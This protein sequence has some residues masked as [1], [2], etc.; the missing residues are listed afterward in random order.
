MDEIKIVQAKEAKNSI[1]KREHYSTLI[2]GL[3]IN[4]LD[5]KF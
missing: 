3:I 1:S 4:R 5:F 2:Y